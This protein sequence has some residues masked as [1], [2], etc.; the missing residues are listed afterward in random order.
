[1]SASGISLLAQAFP[2]LLSSWRSQI[3]VL[4]DRQADHHVAS[5]SICSASM[6]PVAGYEYHGRRTW[7][8][9][10]VTRPLQHIDSDGGHGA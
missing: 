3:Q 7:D 2:L 9:L 8:L 5:P 1:M 4:V 10:N 6:I